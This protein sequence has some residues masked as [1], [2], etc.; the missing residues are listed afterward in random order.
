MLQR[1]Y[2]SSRSASQS[3]WCSSSDGVASSSD[4]STQLMTRSHVRPTTARPR[5]PTTAMS[6]TSS[7]YSTECLPLSQSSIGSRPLQRSTWY[8]CKPTSS[9]SKTMICTS[10]DRVP[11]TYMP[12]T[13]RLAA[14]PK[15][16]DGPDWNP[17]R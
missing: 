17:K 16:A 15:T 1:V 14:K 11:S 2:A 8:V 4:V 13:T 6:T 5:S 9:D 10:S 7:W 12:T 3:E